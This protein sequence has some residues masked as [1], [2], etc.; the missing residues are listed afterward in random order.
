MLTV[1]AVRVT[2]PVISGA[3]VI[4]ALAFLGMVFN[5]NKFLNEFGLIM[6]SGR[7]NRR[8]DAKTILLFNCNCFLDRISCDG[9]PDQCHGTR[10][11]GTMP[12]VS[13]HLCG[14]FILR[15]CIDH[16]VYK[17]THILWCLVY[18]MVCY[19]CCCWL[20]RGPR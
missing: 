3:G 15:V 4:M 17:T 11:P 1:Q 8:C 6:I 20:F 14:R 12:C 2:G 5:T 16:F 19:C 13:V 18:L 9:E 7:S 10:V